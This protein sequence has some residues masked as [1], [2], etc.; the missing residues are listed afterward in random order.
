MSAFRD[1][2]R[3]SRLTLHITPQHKLALKRLVEG[4]GW[5]QAEFLERCIEKA[6]PP[7]LLEHFNFS[8]HFVDRT[9][10]TI[11]GQDGE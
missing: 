8:W 4:F 7:G 6:L 2:S 11:G 5:S 1:T 10:K 9:R 3:L